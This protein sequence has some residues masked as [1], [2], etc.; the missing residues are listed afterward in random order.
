[1]PP[2]LEDDY[3][4][5]SDGVEEEIEDGTPKDTTEDGEG[6]Q[7]LDED[8]SGVSRTSGSAHGGSEDARCEEQAAPAAES[9]SEEEDGGETEAVGAV[10]IRP[11]NASSESEAESEAESSPADAQSAEEGSGSEAEV[12][13]VGEDLSEAENESDTSE[14]EEEFQASSGS[15]EAE[16]EAAV[17]RNS[18]I[19]CKQGE[20]DDPSEDFE[21][22]L[23]CSVC[24]DHSH[25]Q[26][27]RDKSAIND[28]DD[29]EKWRCPTCI[30]NN[31]ESQ[32]P[33]SKT[34]RPR[35]SAPRLVRDLLPVSRGVQRPDSH[36]IFAQP[37]I[38]EGRLRKRKSPTGEPLPQ[39]EK[40]RR[41]A[42]SR[43]LSELSKAA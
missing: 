13:A 24:G 4:E 2:L 8:D 3:E 43:G 16:V 34:S 6:Q 35:S 33:E 7:P 36:S 20:D 11:S 14:E 19:F 17:D 40:R 31:L 1:M 26:C 28:E 10:K 32:S 39:V 38:S 9:G 27:A 30:E 21:P 22:Y 23:T 42:T 12:A 29:V 37:L 15:D 41:K 25:R 18:C 5:S